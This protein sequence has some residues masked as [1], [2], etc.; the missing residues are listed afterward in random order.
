MT[1]F[2]GL[3]A[4]QLSDQLTFWG[5]VYEGLTILP[6]LDKLLDGSQYKQVVYYNSSLQDNLSSREVILTSF[7]GVGNIM[8]TYAIV[9]IG[10]VDQ[11]QIEVQYNLTT[12]FNDDILDQNQQCF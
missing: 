10:S 3:E 9:E 7:T 6:Q 4:I 12:N 11:A 5:P 2:D 1:P 8:L